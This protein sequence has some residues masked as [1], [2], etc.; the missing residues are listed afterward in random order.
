[1][2]ESGLG[3]EKQSYAE[4]AK[5]HRKAAEQGNAHAQRSLGG[6]Y[7]YGWGVKKDFAEA[8]KWYRKAAEQ[9]NVPAQFGLGRMYYFE[10]NNKKEGEKW[11]R[12]A[13]DGGDKVAQDALK[14]IRKKR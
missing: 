4:A 2:Y 12:K 8:E 14:G 7:G 6:I 11:L 9:G 5:W 1:M 13:A 3:V 10:L